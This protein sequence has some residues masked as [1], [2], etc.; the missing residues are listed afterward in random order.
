MS[1]CERLEQDR[2]GCKTWIHGSKDTTICQPLGSFNL[3]WVM[4]GYHK[5]SFEENALEKP[6]T[7][8][9][10]RDEYNGSIIKSFF[11]SS[12]MDQRVSLSPQGSTGA[13]HLGTVTLR[14]HR[15]LQSFYGDRS[16]D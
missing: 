13:H 9:N 15:R 5:S 6:I 10:Y 16:L 2:R 12:T 8:I 11:E 1:E 14:V 4:N 3:Q 7:M